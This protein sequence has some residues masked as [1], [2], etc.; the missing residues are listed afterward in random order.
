M[1]QQGL[2]HSTIKTYLLGFRGKTASYNSNKSMENED[3][4]VPRWRVLQTSHADK[5]VMLWAAA[6]TNFSFCKS[7]EKMKA[8]L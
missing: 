5:P 3:S 8:K 7:G 6:T 1:A 4:M 2:A